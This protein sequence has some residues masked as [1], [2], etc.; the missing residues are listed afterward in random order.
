MN[1]YVANLNST[2]NEQ[3]LIQMFTAY[4]RVT[5]AHIMKDLPT[6]ESRGFGYVEMEDDNAAQTAIDDLH[7]MEWK[8]LILCVQDERSWRDR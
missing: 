2:I 5:S 7:E 6:N 4:G 1:I 3:E 8:T